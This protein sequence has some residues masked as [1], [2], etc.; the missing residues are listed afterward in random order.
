[1]P[2][3]KGAELDESGSV[4]RLKPASAAEAEETAPA[5]FSSMPV[6]VM[7]K[8]LKEVE[9]SPNLADRAQGL[10]NFVHP[11]G[12]NT[13]MTLPQIDYQRQLVRLKKAADTLYG[14]LIPE[15]AFEERQAVPGQ[16]F[17]DAASRIFAAGPLLRF[18]ADQRGQ[19]SDP[20]RPSS[21]ILRLLDRMEDPSQTADA[22]E[23][24]SMYFDHFSKYDQERLFAKAMGYLQ[25]VSQ[26]GSAVMGAAAVAYARRTG[27][28]SNDQKAEAFDAMDRNPALLDLYGRVRSSGYLLELFRRDEPP[29]ED[30][31]RPPTRQSIERSISNIELRV[32]TETG[33][34]EH[35]RTRAQIYLL[36]ELAADIGRVHDHAEMLMRSRPQGQPEHSRPRDARGL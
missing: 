21:H 13:I 5:N 26:N 6:E 20:D 1:M 24:C 19:D 15:V 27:E 33:T 22:V 36:R 18:R 34:A 3:R 32:Q 28:L 4:K 31:K 9:S 17:A 30:W 14:F 35:P 2:K 23:K 8:V 12:M 16:D 10:N 11:L 25:S 29:I 7:L